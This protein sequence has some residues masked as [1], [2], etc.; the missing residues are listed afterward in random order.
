M[1]ARQ[2][3][4]LTINEPPADALENMAKTL[5]CSFR[6]GDRLGVQ[7]LLNEGICFL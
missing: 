1:H 2:R 5:V 3:Q 6:T 4:D 7:N